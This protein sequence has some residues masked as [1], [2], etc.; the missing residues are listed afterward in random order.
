MNKVLPS[1]F[2]F[3]E[4][5]PVVLAVVLPLLFVPSTTEYFETAKV[6]FIYIFTSIIFI[7]WGVKMVYEKRVSFVRSPMDVAMVGIVVAFSLVT[8]FSPSKY[9]AFFGSYLRFTP[10]L[11]FALA[12]VVLY[13]TLSSNLKNRQVQS[14]AVIGFVLSVAAA[15]VLALLAFFGTFTVL[16]LPVSLT[17]M[18]SSAFNT[19]GSLAGLSVLSG[20][21]FVLALSLL[22]T[23]RKTHE[24][25]ETYMTY[26]LNIALFPLL[27]II[28]AY[29][30]MAG[31]VTLIVGLVFLA[32]F[33]GDILK[34]N[35]PILAPLAVW[36]VLLMV[37]MLTPQAT[38]ALKL[39]KPMEVALPLYESWQI[40]SQT[41]TTQPIFGAG[42]GQFAHMFTTL[43]PLSFNNLPI[44]NLRF[45]RPF[46]EILLV[47]AE[48]GILGVVAYLLLFAKIIN[49][50]FGLKNKESLGA[51]LS[52]SLLAL[53]ASLF[54]T[55]GAST[56]YV[57]LILFCALLVAMEENEGSKLA[58]RV[59]V[60]ISTIKDRLLGKV[61]MPQISSTDDHRSLAG[62]NQ[63]LPYI[64]LGVAVLAGLSATAATA[65]AYT[66]EVY[67]RRALT[68]VAQNDGRAAFDSESRAISYNPYVDV[69]QRN[70]SQIAMGVA[71][72]LS[73]RPGVSDSD[74][75]TIQNLI[76]ESI[77]RARVASEIINPLGVSNW[78]T[79]AQV[80][81]GLIGVA[82]NADT[83]TLDSYAQ[84]INLDPTNPNLRILL[85]GV[86]YGIGKF[87]LAASSFA[88]AINLK[89]DIA[90]AHYNL[91]QAFIRL[92]Q[93]SDALSQYDIV[94][95]LIGTTSPD[96]PKAKQEREGLARQ[97][98]AETATPA[99]S[100]TRRVNGENPSGFP[101]ATG[102]GQPALNAPAPAT[103]L[104]KKNVT[105]P[106]INLGN[107][108]EAS[109][110]AGQ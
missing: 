61:G 75:Q 98:A 42:F 6:A 81:Q 82:A 77:R 93:K 76:Q 43:K 110:A 78:E 80:Y 19:V 21:A 84:A 32:V 79:R 107:P 69:Y 102:T 97:V 2:K 47:L 8:V 28:L 11:G 34:K 36:A 56:I 31:W 17:F 67:N 9:L 68:A 12:L 10:G 25:Y 50:S 103:N 92:N 30:T 72:N 45:D 91:A 63:I 73:S 51:G 48:A 13:Y 27:A 64:M 5:S 57:T 46:N 70:L 23:D 41:I 71:V 54:V 37:V 52:A 24:S 3:L 83:W 90:N 26:G 60:M 33:E 20:L 38:K 49:L 29:G 105:P 66:A 58:E 109:P 74:K 35:K 106:E 88:T 95:N 62:V 85:G 1:L 65:L 89:P 108:K 99:D 104:Q 96:Y 101:S 87:D 59:V 7:V 55:V 40:A 15:A 86:Y 39:N 14:Y 100:S 18:Q 4:Y 16:P 44:W 94:L 53:V 22:A